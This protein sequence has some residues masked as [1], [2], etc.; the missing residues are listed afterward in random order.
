ME[1]ELPRG[2]HYA[3]T[4]GEQRSELQ[5]S[6]RKLRFR[7]RQQ[8]NERREL[9]SSDFRRLGIPI[10]QATTNSA[11]FTLLRQYYGDRVR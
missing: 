6:D 9:L 11:P 3:V 2:G 4:D 7:Y 1:G 10:L 5:T 8:F